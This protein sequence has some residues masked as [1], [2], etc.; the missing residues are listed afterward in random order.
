MAVRQGGVALRN[1]APV[2]FSQA[3]GRVSAL[4]LPTG[5]QRNYPAEY[6]KSHRT[7]NPVA[8]IWLAQRRHVPAFEILRRRSRIITFITFR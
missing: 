4:S 8:M 2:C 1:S 6:H 7:A 3:G 5:P